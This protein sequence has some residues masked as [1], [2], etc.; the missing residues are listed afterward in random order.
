YDKS[1]DSLRYGFHPRYQDNR[2]FRLKRSVEPIIFNQVARDSQKFKRL[3]KKRTAVERVNG[4]IDRD[5]RFEK[6]TIRGLKKMSLAIA[7]SFLVMVGFALA[8]LKLGQNTHLA[9][10]VV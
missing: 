4:R 9:S 6:H 7:M 1:C 2:I 8:K 10:W 5:F 3:Y